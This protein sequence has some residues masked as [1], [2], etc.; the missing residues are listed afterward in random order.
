MEQVIVAAVRGQAFFVEYS[1]GQMHPVREGMVLAEGDILLTSSNGEVELRQSGREML[2]VGPSQQLEVVDNGDE[3]PL[4]IAGLA[5]QDLTIEQIQQAL[6][7]GQDPTAVIEAPAAIAL[8]VSSAHNSG[9]DLLRHAKATL[10]QAGYDTEYRRVEPEV[11]DQFGLA[12]QAS[13][14]TGG[15]LPI[16]FQLL[17]GEGEQGNLI[18][19][20][21]AQLAGFGQLL[22]IA[23]RPLVEWPLVSDGEFVGARQVSLPYGEFYVYPDGSYAFQSLPSLDHSSSDSLPQIP[24]NLTFQD[25]FGGIAETTVIVTIDDGADPQGITADAEVTDAGGSDEAQLRI[26]GGSDAI[27][28]STLGFDVAAIVAGLTPLQLTNQGVALD[29]DNLSVTDTVLLISDVNGNPVLQLTLQPPLLGN[30][31]LFVT[32]TAT[33]L[34]PLDH[35]DNA[36]Q[37]PIF[38]AGSDSD[39]DPFSAEL[40][41]T[42]TDTV[43]LAADV[44]NS[45]SETEGG[46]QVAGNLLDN[47]Q[48]GADGAAAAGGVTVVNGV[49]LSTQTAIS[50]GEFDGYIQV[51][52][53]NGTLYVKPTG[54]YIF[55]ADDNLD[56]GAGTQQE[57]EADIVFDV[58]FTVEDFDGDLSDANLN[59]TIVDGAAPTAATVS[60]DV[61][62]D[63][64]SDQVNLVIERGS[65]QL[66]PASFGFDTDAISSAIAALNLTSGGVAVDGSNLS[67]SNGVLT[68][69]DANNNP[70]LSVT[71]GNPTDNNGDL[72]FPVT[73]NPLAPLDHLGSGNGAS[74]SLPIFIK[75]QDSDNDPVT[76]QVT[77]NVAD[78][79]PTA[80]GVSN[81]VTEAEGGAQVAGNLL[82]NTQFGADGAAAAGGV[83]VVNSVDLSTQTAIS[84]GA[85]DGYIEVAVDNGTLYVKPTGE[86]IFVADDNLDHGAGTAQDPEADIVFDVPFT[87]ED[88]DGDPSNA[89]LNLTIVDGAAPTAATV[90]VDVSDDGSSDQVNLVV[91]RGS[92][93]LDPASFGFDTGAIS[94]AI[95]ALNLTSAG[96]AVDGSNLTLLGSTLTILDG[97]DN[98]VLEV[99][100]GLPT[101]TNGDLSFPV[102]VNPLAP[103]D[104]FGAG[105]DTSF[106]LPI[107]IKGQDSDNDPVSGQVTVNVADTTPTA[108]GVSNQ[109]IETEGGAQV[110]GNL[111]DNTQFGADGA[112]A[113]GGVTVVN[114]VDLS[115]QTAI[116]GGA[117]DGYIEVAVDNGSLYVKPTGEYIFVAD[118]NLDHGAGTAQDPEADIVFDVPFTVEDF[119]GDP[120]DANLNL[121]I[122]DG[123]APTAEVVA[124]E[125]TD[126]LDSFT[127]FPTFTR[128]SDQL[129]PDSVAF[130]VA[131][132]AAALADAGLTSVGVGLDLDN[133]YLTP[134]GSTMII[135]DLNGNEVIKATLNPLRISDGEI[136]AP[137]NVQIVAPLDHQGDQPLEFPLYLSASD[138]D[139]D[140]A[141]ARIDVTVIDGD[142]P[143]SD[144][145]AVTLDDGVDSFT[146]RVLFE[147]GSDPLVSDTVAFDIAAIQQALAPLQLSSGGADLNLDNIFISGNTLIIRDVD[148]NEV[149][150]ATINQVDQQGD[151]VSV[152]VN[153]QLVAPLDHQGDQLQFP[154]ILT[155][156]D[157][158]G[159]SVHGQI[160]VTV[161]DA[162]PQAG[163]VSNSLTETEGGSQVS[164]NLLDNTQ[165][166]ADGAIDGGAVVTVNGVQLAQQPQVLGGEF[167]GY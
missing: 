105:N 43:P 65:D 119:D 149:I 52:V 96:G 5:S 62:D 48:F 102:T 32:V 90:S 9:A 153:V 144:G 148:G 89:N 123:A 98:P 39:G 131:A 139:N 122:V 156:D 115:T 84:G 116:N 110:A 70:V 87:V 104:H 6:L 63:G 99:I 109:V 55:V 75:G 71:L 127:V 142:G 16:Q 58:P 124:V 12:S 158:D 125:L 128:G 2:L 42:V 30:N 92:D 1:T 166:G 134:S 152:A 141:Q 150:K 61:S 64:S 114:G 25:A 160:A 129:D 54:E 108:A 8:L 40:L 13:Q 93:Q 31:D 72:S 74:L 21:G 161:T 26:F 38:L 29:L 24:L 147:P 28:A 136:T 56:H 11:D 126:G 167:D 41:L 33:S 15:I 78:T 46:S 162:E 18:V 82:D 85:F 66:D 44:S 81:Q 101:E 45:L 121:T 17:E 73:V 4:D 34:A 155:I 69:F 76:G 163:D 117:F 146:V 22:L 140:S 79:S 113:A 80:A 145:A 132:I 154:V 111:L 137:V 135:R 88:F 7:S 50:G 106:S 14:A 35:V 23:G 77:V 118:D 51:D 159:D 165:L 143:S 47:T 59:L 100:L 112:A 86:Y 53:D 36:L 3:Q 19:D 133:I 151:D 20:T 107:F 37:L 91:E 10:A 27:D 83:T 138:I 94:N 97:N 67:V 130:D 95:A 164:G 60:V 103:L 57:P 49:D 157:S 68:V 120:S